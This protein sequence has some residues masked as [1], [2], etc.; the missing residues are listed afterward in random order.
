MNLK[1]LKSALREIRGSLG[2][3]LAIF[4]IVI[5]GVG[6]FSGLSICKEAMI[7]TADN[8]AHERNMYDFRVL[9]TLG[10]TDDDIANFEDEEY[11]TAVNAAYFTDALVLDVFGAER[12][13]R[14]HSITDDINEFDLLH[15]RMPTADNECIAD[16]EFFGEWALSRTIKVAEGNTDGVLDTLAYD[17]YTIVG[18]GNLPYYMNIERP[19]SDIGS[20][21]ISAY[22]CIPEGGFS[23]EYY[24]EIYITIDSDARI[25]SEE[26]IA[27]LDD[28]KDDIT[29][30]AEKNANDRYDAIV[31]EIEAAIALFP[32]PQMAS[33][34]TIP[35]P[36]SVFT[37]T[38]EANISYVSYQNDSNIVGGIARV[39]PVFFFLV[40]ALVCVTTMSRMVEEQRT[41]IGV[42]KS[43]GYGNG[44]IMSKYLLY[45]GSAGIFGCLIGYFGGTYLFPA[46]IWKA[47]NMLYPF[48]DSMAFVFDSA[49]L[50]AALAVTCLCTVGVTVI[51]CHAT[52]RSQAASLI[53]PKAP[54]SGKR[55][56][57]ERVT[58]I[59][60][61]LS[62]LQKVSL[63]NL[64]R[65]RQRFFMMI[66]GIGGCTA[67]LVGGFGIR[68]SINNVVTDQYEKIIRYDAEVTFSS[69]PESKADF[70]ETHTGLVEDA[71][72]ISISSIDISIGDRAK[73]ISV[74]A[75]DGDNL[76]DFFSLNFENEEVSF[77]KTGEIIINSGL[78]NDM[79]IAVGDK[80]TLTSKGLKTVE[81]TVSGIFKNYIGNFAYV[82]HETAETFF[83]K[84]DI[85]GA[86]VIYDDGAEPRDVT[87]ALLTDENVSSAAVMEN[88]KNGISDTMKSLN[89]IVLVVI[90]C[91]GALAFVVLYNLANIN[92][93]ERL[94]EIASIKVLG[95]YDNE[96]ST[97]IFRENNILT[98][99]GAMV[100]LPLGKFLHAY[101]MLQVNI[102]FIKFDTYVNPWSYLYSALLTLAFALVMQIIMNRR[103]RRINMAE[104]LKTV[105]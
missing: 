83:D 23:S 45:S 8:Y 48:T 17:E 52:L 95:F 11:V 34:I 102:E 44:A 59:W 80:V 53:R 39:F 14:V 4:A 73:N 66:I 91:A 24:H 46:V 28:V 22:V 75:P 85:N 93:T 37:L 12:V 27:D 88:R 13:F 90:I 58:P 104:S 29:A 71:L 57:F 76:G 86:Y 19:T 9:S 79:D 69:Q 92:I 87:A 77:P 21:G 70:L 43:L 63:R 65:Y 89:Y 18:V 61:H 3:Y 56:I 94:R 74:N 26:Y 47:F 84:G 50:T 54:K 6:F 97:Y 38:R 15:G 99:L 62:F 1:M 40:A 42:L 105:E 100:G 67:L 98:A 78:A 81:A 96:T 7:T 16:G 33:G 20:G 82:S 25:F 60:K 2:R 31:A 51:C 55:T 5:I 35:P 41:Q 32:D 103:L 10:F 36:P 49:L 101:V 64:F 30:I 72:Y 68:D